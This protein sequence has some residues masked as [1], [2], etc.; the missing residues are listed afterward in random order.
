MVAVLPGGV[1]GVDAG[2]GTAAAAAA[3]SGVGGGG[4]VGVGVGA[5][6]AVAQRSSVVVG[7]A[8]WRR[9]FSWRSGRLG[10]A[11]EERLQVY[12]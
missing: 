6:A 8:V 10:L 4:F 7:F 1:R 9:F 3:G 12:V 11:C 5:A 2:A